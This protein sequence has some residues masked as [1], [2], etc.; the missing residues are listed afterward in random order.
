MIRVLCLV[1]LPD[2]GAGNRLRIV[3]Y[4]PHLREQGIELEVSRFFDD[5]AYAVLYQPGHTR[6]KVLAVLRGIGRR[7]RDL[8]RATRYDLVLVYRES[9][10]LG[11]PIFERILRRRGIPY[12]FD[13]DDAIFLAPIH[14]VNRAWTWLR[15][16]SRVAETARGAVSV[17]VGNEYLA[18]HARRWNPDVAVIPTPVDT[19]RHRPRAVTATD[20]RPVIGWIGS[21]TTAPYLNILDRPLAELASRRAFRFRVVGGAYRHDV[22]DVELVPYRLEAEPDVIAGFDIGVLPE[23]D[24][25]WTRGKGAFKALLYMATGIPVVASRVGVNAEVVGEGEAG[26][27][28]DGDEDWLAALE[29]LIDDPALR[30]RL[31]ATGRARVEHRYS[32]RTQVPRLARVLRAAAGRS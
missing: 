26:Y 22:A 13:F 11:P 32:L 9:A 24:D 2:S 6:R 27:C 4:G 31:G 29:R 8:M 16:H 30:S 10:P 25:A 7:L 21:S 5:A 12:V 23:P 1:T 19:D 14:P 15:H 20:R 28:V 17:I 18:E 3:Q